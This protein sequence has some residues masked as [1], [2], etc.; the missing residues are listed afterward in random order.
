MFLRGLIYGQTAQLNTT[1]DTWQITGVQLEA[2]ST[3][4]S[5]AHENYSDT[6][7]KCQR[8][9]YRLDN[10]SLNAAIGT[11]FNQSTTNS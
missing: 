1:N 2:G 4:S 3:A 5:F 11:G 10:L 6:L 7:R 9:Y 8:F